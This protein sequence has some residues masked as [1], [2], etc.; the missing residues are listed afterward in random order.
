MRPRASFGFAGLPQGFGGTAL[1]CHRL[2][3]LVASPPPPLLVPEEDAHRDCQSCSAPLTDV[4]KKKGKST[5]PEMDH[6][7]GGVFPRVEENIFH[8]MIRAPLGP[9]PRDGVVG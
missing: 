3:Q 7:G 9:G 6:R 1:T 4:K 8:Q 2:N 5:P